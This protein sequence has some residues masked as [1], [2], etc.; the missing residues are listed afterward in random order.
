MCIR[1]NRWNY[2]IHQRGVREMEDKKE[3]GLPILVWVL[4]IGMA[5]ALVAGFV[6]FLK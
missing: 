1:I 6:I 5:A 3:S 2:G 4:I